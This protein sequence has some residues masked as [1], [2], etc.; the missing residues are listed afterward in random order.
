MKNTSLLPRGHNVEN[1]II[2]IIIIIRRRRRPRKAAPN[3]PLLHNYCTL[4]HV[5]YSTSS[6][7][8]FCVWLFEYNRL[9]HNNWWRLRWWRW[10]WRFNITWMKWLLLYYYD[11]CI[12]S[13][14]HPLVTDVWFRTY[15]LDAF[16]F[17]LSLSPILSSLSLVNRTL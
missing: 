14:F 12:L 17:A 1:R 8:P 10:R 4:L 15:P 7:K 11:D 2:I 5:K 3:A 6:P 13:T 9:P 16:F